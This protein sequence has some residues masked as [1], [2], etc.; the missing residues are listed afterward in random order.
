MTQFPTRLKLAAFGLTAFALT[1]ASAVAEPKAEARTAVLQNVI[2]C[3]G[4]PAATERLACYDAAVSRLDVAEKKGDIVV[5]DRDQARAARKQAFGF[6]MPSLAMFD[7][8]EKPEDLDRVT[9]SVVRATQSS[10]RRWTVE[11][12]GG[13]VWAQNDDEVLGRSPKAGSKVEIRKASMGYFMNLDG[14][15]AVRARRVK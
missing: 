14:Q 1:S 12:E 3:R 11:L 5:V 6:T 2:D 10:D 13:A 15:R 8:G 7:R 9:T 4:K